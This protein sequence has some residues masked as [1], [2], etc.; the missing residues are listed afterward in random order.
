MDYTFRAWRV[1][2]IVNANKPVVD[3]DFQ[4]TYDDENGDEQPYDFSAQ[5]GLFL[6]FKDR[7]DGKVLAEWSHLN[8]LTLIDNAIRWNEYDASEM[9]FAQG[10]GKVWY[11]IGY[12]LDDYTPVDIEMLLAY[13]VAKC[14]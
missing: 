13:G 12:I 2:I 14:E 4:F 3:C 8:G 5:D 10:G 9:A 11:E 1:D 7:K 6:K